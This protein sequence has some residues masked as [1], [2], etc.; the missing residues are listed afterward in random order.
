M[1]TNREHS[2]SLQVRWSG[3]LGEGTSEY[4]AYS[5]SHE[6]IGTNKPTI[7]GSAD[8]SFRGDRDR[9]NPEELLVASLSSCHMLWYLHLCSDA[10]IV[11]VSYVDN[12][13]GTMVETRSGDGHFQEVILQPIVR[14][15]SDRNLDKARGLHEEAHRLCFIANSVNFPVRC[16]PTIERAN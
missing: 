11:A 4:T 6:I 10:G 16:Q 1:K 7:L 14:I 15:S 5:R 3:N 9:Y 8:P 2:Y 13:I 12:P